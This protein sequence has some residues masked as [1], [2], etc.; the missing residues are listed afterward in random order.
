VVHGYTT[1]FSVSAVL[2]LLAAAAAA[3]LIRASRHDVVE[4]HETGAEPALA[5]ST[6]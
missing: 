1:A 3:G 6:A 2:L 4:G 5:G